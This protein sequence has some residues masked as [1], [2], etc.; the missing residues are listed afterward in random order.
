MKKILILGGFGFMGKNLN[1]ILDPGKY[2]LESQSRR[3]GCDMRDLVTLRDKIQSIAPDII[4]MAAANVGSISYVSKYAA[5]V[6]HDNTLMYVNL[7]QAVTEVNPGIQIINPIS[8]CS[9]PGVIDIQDEDSWWDGA[10]HESVEAYGTPKKI[11]F[12]ISRCYQRQHGINTVNLIVPNAYGPHD[13]M[14][15]ERTHAM[16]GIIMRMIKSKMSGHEEFCLWG[17]GKPIRE[18]VY[19]ADVAR[20]IAKIIDDDITDLPNPLNIGQQHGISINDSVDI[21]KRLLDYPVTVQHDVS[22]QDGAPVKI[23]GN[24]LFRKYFP[25]FDFTDYHTGITETINYY[26]KLL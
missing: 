17:S 22:K 24:G 20:L 19:M 13:Y 2:I 9:Y 5:N 8:N 18:W 23:I 4:I 11:G 7:Y 16:N 6:V 10:I 21:I 3:T 25:D 26:T 1:Q 14:D 12:I 15:E